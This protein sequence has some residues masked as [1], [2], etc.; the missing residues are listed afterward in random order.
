MH[1]TAQKTESKV[2]HMPKSGYERPSPHH[3]LGNLP[4]DM[5]KTGQGKPNHNLH[6][7]NTTDP[8]HYRAN[9]GYP[10]RKPKPS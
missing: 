9:S 7:Q 10:V 5:Q 2:M 3:K 8:F 1:E 4:P 6:T